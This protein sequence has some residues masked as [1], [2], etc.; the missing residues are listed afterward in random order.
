M[1]ILLGVLYLHWWERL[2]RSFLVLFLSDFDI[3]FA[4]GFTNDVGS[5]FFLDALKKF[6]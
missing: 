5:V 4:G 6:P 2:D 3:R 1:C